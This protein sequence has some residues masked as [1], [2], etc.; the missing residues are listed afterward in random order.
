MGELRRGRED[1]V[2]VDGGGGKGVMIVVVV[3]VVW[4]GLAGSIHVC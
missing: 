4:V 1:L 2:V 3:V